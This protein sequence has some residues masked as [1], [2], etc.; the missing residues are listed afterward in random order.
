MSEATNQDEIHMTTPELIEAHGYTSET[1]YVWTEDG[2]RLDVHRVISRIEEKKNVG[3][4]DKKQKN[5]VES[6]KAPILVSHGLLSSSAD[7]VLLGPDNALAYYLCDNGFDVWLTNARG[8]AYSMK[9]KV[10]MTK[11]KEFWDFSWH[12]IGY[13]DLPATIDYILEHTGHMELYYVGY[14]QGSTAFFV[15]ASERPEY[16]RKVKGMIGLAP[17]AFLAH[18]R[19]PLIKFVVHFGILMEVQ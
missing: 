6:Y 2:Y 18:Q 8:N 11:D 7:W 5:L 13:Y 16:N 14:S 4:I 15:M 17:I 12:E 1:H 19:S 9:H 3:S 10:Y